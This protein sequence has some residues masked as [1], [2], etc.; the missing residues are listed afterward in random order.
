MTHLG[1]VLVQ[2]NGK[3]MNQTQRD[4]SNEEEAE[5]LVDGNAKRERPEWKD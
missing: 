1:C 2:R 5:G 4:L 3:K